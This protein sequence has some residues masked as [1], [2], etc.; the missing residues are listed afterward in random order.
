VAL[1]AATLAGFAGAAYQDV[2]LAAAMPDEGFANCVRHGP[3]V[4]TTEL[5]G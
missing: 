2:L 5:N 1:G 4:P 3:C